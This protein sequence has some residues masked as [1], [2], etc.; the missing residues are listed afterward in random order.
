MPVLGSSIATDYWESSDIA[1]GLDR[2]KAAM[3]TV[4]IDKIGDMAVLEYE[5]GIVG[6]AAALGLRDAVTS[7]GNARIIVLDLS[8]VDTVDNSCLGILVLLQDWAH[9]HAIQF[10]LFNPSL[11]VR[12]RLEQIR[13]LCELQ[14]ATLDEVIALLAQAESRRAVAA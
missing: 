2:K 5:G 4:G 8:E 12:H 1:K 3:L 10:K 14:I 9:A 7:Q 6:G 11:S 13:L